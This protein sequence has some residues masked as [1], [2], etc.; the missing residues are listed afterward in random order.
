M[1][2]VGTSAAT[3]KCQRTIQQ[4]TRYGGSMPVISVTWEEAEAGG[5]E[6]HGMQ[7]EVREQWQEL[8][9][10]FH[11]VSPRDWTQVT[12]PGARAEWSPRVLELNT[13]YTCHVF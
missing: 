11:H 9:L 13:S 12:R 4:V 1:R 7:V 10:C 8:V 6:V 5:L 3:E 2:L